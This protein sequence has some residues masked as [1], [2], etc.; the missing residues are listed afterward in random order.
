MLY[1]LW[2]QEGSEKTLALNYI[3]QWI[4]GSASWVKVERIGRARPRRSLSRQLAEK[5]RKGWLRRGTGLKYYSWYLSCRVVPTFLLI[6]IL[7]SV[8]NTPHF[9]KSLCG[10]PLPAAYRWDNNKRGRYIS[11]SLNSKFKIFSQGILICMISS[12]V[13]KMLYKVE[14][15]FIGL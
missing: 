4:S 7:T 12:H 2:E 5:R 3:L 8:L 9:L 14:T 13:T 15:A 10:D 11:P 1:S 6:R